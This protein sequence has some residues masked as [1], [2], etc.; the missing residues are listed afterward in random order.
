MLKTRWIQRKTQ[1][2]VALGVVLAATK[3]GFCR[4]DSVG[5]VLLFVVVD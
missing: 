5:V 3:A 1:R 4:V 2:V